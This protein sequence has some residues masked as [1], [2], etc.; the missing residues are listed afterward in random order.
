MRFASLGSGSEGNAL[1]IS[2]TSG[3][4]ET[5]VMLDCG[6]G[7]REAESRLSHLHIDP[8]Q[9]SGI[10][11][12]H[13][14]QDHVGGVFRLARRHKIPVWMTHGTL[15]SVRDESDGVTVHICRDIEPFVIGDLEIQPYTVPHDAR[16]P[17]QYTATDG[18]R[19]LGVLTDVGH[20]TPHLMKALNGCD[21]LVL[22]FN[23]DTEMLSQS[24]YP[25]WLKARIGGQLGH[26]S[27][28]QS[29]EILQGLDRSRL[30][31]VIAAHLSQKNNSPD[32]VRSLI[33]GVLAGSDVEVVI[34]DQ[35]SG[36]D[37]MI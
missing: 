22:E 29:T 26:L 21:A 3:I 9:L 19:K 31:R 32:K 28:Q 4:T 11:V 30:Q 14:H 15:E 5:T 16:E 13:E 18:I 25:P 8:K 33:Q 34:A 17:V 24:V 10:I 35:E 27:N 23:H 12:T 6:F 1:L 36:F 20:S 2:A 7:L 37:W